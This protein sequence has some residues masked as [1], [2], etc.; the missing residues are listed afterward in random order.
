MKIDVDGIEHLILKGA[1]EVLKNKNLKSIS[2]ELNENFKKQFNDVL[3][4]MKKFKF[5][6]IGKK[7]NE[8]YELYKYSKFKKIFNYYFER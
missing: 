4:I 2:I 6:I 3:K 5:K 1:T 8:N 7:R